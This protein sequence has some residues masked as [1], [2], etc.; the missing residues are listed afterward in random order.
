[1]SLLTEVL[2]YIV[3]VIEVGQDL[4]EGGH[5]DVK[6]KNIAQDLDPLNIGTKFLF[7]NVPNVGFF[8][9]GAQPYVNNDTLFS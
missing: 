4:Q 9:K 3:Q 8:L 6:E 7:Q 5:L 2:V 1:M